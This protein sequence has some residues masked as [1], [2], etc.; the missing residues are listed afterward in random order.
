MLGTM[1]LSLSGILE[2]E[3]EYALPL[4]DSDGSMNGSRVRPNARE[5]PQH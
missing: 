2:S 5:R 1:T 3:R 4:Y